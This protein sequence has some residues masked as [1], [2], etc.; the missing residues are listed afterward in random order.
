MCN[1]R[2]VTKRPPL[3]T[4]DVAERLGKSIKT[5][6]RMAEAGEIPGARKL[7]GQTGAWYFDPELFEHWF[8][9]LERTT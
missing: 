7:P 5:V 8:A 9:A 4:A 1:S 6:Q 2:H 3:L